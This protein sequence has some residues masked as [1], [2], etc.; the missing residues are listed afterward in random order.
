MAF[1]PFYLTYFQI[2]CCTIFS[3]SQGYCTVCLKPTSQARIL[4]LIYKISHVTS[5]YCTIMYMYWHCGPAPRK[6]KK[7]NIVKITSPPKLYALFE[8]A[9]F[10]PQHNVTLLE[11]YCIGLK[12][13]HQASITLK[14]NSAERCQCHLQR[15]A[16]KLS[17]QSQP[18]SQLCQLPC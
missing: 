12:N 16:T 1:L 17:I 6:R 14:N 8:I 5:Q 10:I 9:Y 2:S 3:R 11:W 13:S 15:M 4:N 18:S 7:Q